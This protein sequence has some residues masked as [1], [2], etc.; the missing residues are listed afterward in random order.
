MEKLLTIVV[1]AYNVEKYIKNCLDSFIDLS[2]LRSLEILIVDD[3]STDS[4]ASGTYLRANIH[5]TSRCSP[6]RTET[7]IYHQL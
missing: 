2:V 5:T 7:W 6:R 4:T 1:P 3:G